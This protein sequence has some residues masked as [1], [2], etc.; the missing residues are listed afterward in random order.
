MSERGEFTPPVEIAKKEKRMFGFDPNI[1][2]HDKEIVD[3]HQSREY[4]RLVGL[5]NNPVVLENLVV[6]KGEGNYL[7][8]LTWAVDALHSELTG[9]PLAKD[10]TAEGIM[11]LVNE[12]GL[13]PMVISEVANAYYHLKK[14]NESRK[15]AGILADEASG[16]SVLV[17]ANALNCLASLT[18]KQEKPKEARDL[19]QQAKT[20][21]VQRL[22]DASVVGSERANLEWQEMKVDHGLLYDK[23]KIKQ[24]PDMPDKLVALAEKREA[25][26][27]T[28]LVA[29]T[30]LDVAR[31]HDIMGNNDQVHHYL[32]KAI[33]GLGKIGYENALKDAELLEQKLAKKR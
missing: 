10:I 17:Q 8:H 11:R 20:R 27:D 2:E 23:A 22:S 7:K 21:L 5:L 24:F 30:Y 29:R 26:G 6:R 33:L 9:K 18:Y 4:D 19:N 3:A 1:A 32:D 15:I 31:L 16:F 28:L 14:N 25:T 12:M 13:D